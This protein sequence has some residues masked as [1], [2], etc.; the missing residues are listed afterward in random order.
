M[1]ANFTLRRLEYF[2]AVGEAGSI[3]GASE[4][5]KVSSPSISAALAQLEDEVS[6]QLFV[7]RRARGMELTSGGRRLF[8]EAKKVLRHA[9]NMQ[10]IMSQSARKPFM[11]RIHAV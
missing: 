2:I 11:S 6:A 1:H 4:K 9:W 10:G 3:A 8:D 7:R 5:L